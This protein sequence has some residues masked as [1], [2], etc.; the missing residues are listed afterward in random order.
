MSARASMMELRRP[1]LRNRGR[2]R[3]HRLME[4]GTK[5]RVSSRIKIRGSLLSGRR[6]PCD[7]VEFRAPG[8][9]IRE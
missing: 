3:R 2:K 4:A 5:M 6:K 7:S 8:R 9:R 1:P